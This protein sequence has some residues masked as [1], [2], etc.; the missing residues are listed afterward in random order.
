MS[1]PSHLAL[2]N[3]NR[4]EQDDNQ[5]TMQCR[6]VLGANG[7][8]NALGTNW[9]WD[10]FLQQ[11]SERISISIPL[12][13]NK[14]N[15]ALGMDSVAN[16]ANGLPICRSTLANP[17][18]GCVPYD[19]FGIGVNTQAAI[20]YVTGTDYNYVV[21]TQ[22]QMGANLNGEPFSTWAGPVSLATGIEWRRESANGYKPNSC[23]CGKQLF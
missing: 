3:N 4:V 20:N 14:T 15:L 19:P 10:G 6:F 16:P 8:F 11:S 1:H 23:R 2:P 9:K 21:L 7:A 18:N 22:D 13:V 17:T 12:D 5:R